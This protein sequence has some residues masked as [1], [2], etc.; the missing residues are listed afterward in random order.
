MRFHYELLG[1]AFCKTVMKILSKR[2]GEKKLFGINPLVS[3]DGHTQRNIE[4]KLLYL[5]QLWYDTFMMHESEFRE[6]IGAYKNLRKEGVIFPQRDPNEAFMI[7]FT[8]TTS[9]IFQTMEDNRIYEDP[10]K[11]LNP[12]K[13]YKVNSDYFS[14]PS[15]Q[16]GAYE[17]GGANYQLPSGYVN[18]RN[19]EIIR[20]YDQQQQVELE[21]GDEGVI[22][23]EEITILKESCM[24][25]DDIITNAQHINDLRGEVAVEIIDNHTHSLKK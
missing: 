12:N 14:D 15:H 20:E 22:S 16:G 2:R 11:Q 8:G 17:G 10:I 25:M 7:K 5:I 23:A 3:K 1:N 19:Q 4:D 18:D 9:P 13:S 24:L 21:T 6:I